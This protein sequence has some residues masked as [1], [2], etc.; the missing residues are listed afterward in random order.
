MSTTE[1]RSFEDV[2]WS[3]DPAFLLL[4]SSSSEAE[5][6]ACQVRASSRDSRP[7]VNEV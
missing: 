7:M 4:L 6:E 5:S 2:D 1:K 3:T